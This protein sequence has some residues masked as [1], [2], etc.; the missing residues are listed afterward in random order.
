VDHYGGG[1]QTYLV[2]SSKVPQVDAERGVHLMASLKYTVDTTKFIAKPEASR[3]TL[4]DVM[5]L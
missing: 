3:D 5:Q 1:R 4:V 2:E